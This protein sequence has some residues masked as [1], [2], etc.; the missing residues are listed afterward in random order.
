MGATQG[1]QGTNPTQPEA[2]MARKFARSVK[3][4]LHTRPAMPFAPN[5]RRKADGSLG[6][7]PK[8]GALAIG[9]GRFHAAVGAARWLRQLLPSRKSIRA[10]NSHYGRRLGCNKDAVRIFIPP[11]SVFERSEAF[12]R[13]GFLQFGLLFE[14][15]IVILPDESGAAPSSRE[16]SC[17]LSPTF[18]T[19]PVGLPRPRPPMVPDDATFV[20][21]GVREPPFVLVV[22]PTPC[23]PGESSKGGA[24]S[25]GCGSVAPA[26][27]NVPVVE[28][29]P[30]NPV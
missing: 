27:P 2:P 24:F 1:G 30:P 20:V 11:R 25:I 23:L 15:G 26:P 29:L 22:P 9:C 16:S 4:Y 14:A 5:L 8:G 19:R 10:R 12:V 3:G 7:G 28:P 18:I 21:G 17:P 13:P 6:R